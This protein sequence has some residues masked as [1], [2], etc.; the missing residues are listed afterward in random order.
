M[1]SQ[2]LRKK[3]SVLPS[4]HEKTK[5][6]LEFLLEEAL[7]NKQTELALILQETINCCSSIVSGKPS[8]MSPADAYYTLLFLKNF[9]EL[10]FQERAKMLELLASDYSELF[11]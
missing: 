6:V 2:K 5:D 9:F 8:K 4:A 11:S 7:R 1:S 10:D 3:K